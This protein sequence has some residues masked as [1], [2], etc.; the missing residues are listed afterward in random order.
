MSDHLILKMQLSERCVQLAHLQCDDLDLRLQ[1][2]PVT[3]L[4]SRGHK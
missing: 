1:L 3:Y 4:H 2:N